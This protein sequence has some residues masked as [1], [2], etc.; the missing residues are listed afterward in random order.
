MAKKNGIEL[1]ELSI[2]PGKDD[3]LY[4]GN[5]YVDGIKI[6]FW[7][8]KGDGISDEITMEDGFSEKKFFAYLK[9]YPNFVQEL[10]LLSLDEMQYQE[11]CSHG[12]QT[13]VVATDLESNTAQYFAFRDASK[14]TF[15]ALVQECK[16]QL[17]ENDTSYAF[18]VYTSPED[19]R[20][21]GRIS[22][23]I[24]SSRL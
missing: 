3:I 14:M 11:Y 18:Q 6:A 24:F 23:V 13:M 16:K 1:R 4:S 20:A 7:K 2:L 21:K 12:Y 8:Q 15:S 9:K 22:S 5:L 17:S 10:L 19:F